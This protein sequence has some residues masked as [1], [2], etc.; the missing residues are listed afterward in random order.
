VKIWGSNFLIFRLLPC[1]YIE[2]RGVKFWEDKN[3]VASPCGFIRR[4]ALFSGL[5][6]Y[7][8]YS[9]P[10]P[11]GT[12]EQNCEIFG[13]TRTF[14][15]T[16]KKGNVKDIIYNTNSKTINQSNQKQN[17]TLNQQYKV[18]KLYSYMYILGGGFCIQFKH[19]LKTDRW[20]IRSMY[21][22]ILC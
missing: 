9:N 2:K 6:R 4:T 16:K 13:T 22:L 3:F 20:T 21:K 18:T 1:V 17:L 12:F 19:N 10:D 14:F 11:H 8:I 5:L 15:K 7:R